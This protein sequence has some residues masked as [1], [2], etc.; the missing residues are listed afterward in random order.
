LFLSVSHPL[1]FLS[2]CDL[3][4]DVAVV[5]DI[6]NYC[7]D[8]CRRRHLEAKG[9]EATGKPKRAESRGERR[10]LGLEEVPTNREL[11]VQTVGYDFLTWFEIIHYEYPGCIMAPARTQAELDYIVQLDLLGPTLLGVFKDPIL[12]AEGCGTNN[13]LE[14]WNTFE[15]PVDED[16]G[17]WSTY[18]GG[19]PDGL[20]D[21][22]SAVASVANASPSSGMFDNAANVLYPYVAIKCYLDPSENPFENFPG[23]FGGNFPW[24]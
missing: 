5:Y 4:G 15:G 13:C 21:G 14:D 1:F 2:L 20:N 12:A 24:S 17:L 6:L 23:L 8:V 10:R 19:Q 3:K 22:T 18:G 16:A 9:G 11:G 7:G